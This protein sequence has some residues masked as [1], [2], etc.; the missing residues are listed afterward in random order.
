MS[1]EATDEISTFGWRSF[2]SQHAREANSDL[3]VCEG[4]IEGFN[5]FYYKAAQHTSVSDE[6][7]IITQ[8]N[9]TNNLEI[10]SIK[11]LQHNIISP[12]RFTVVRSRLELP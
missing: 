12:L 2:K 1:R 8:C 5:A 10:I 4:K 7:K 9:S 6:D 3:Y 11:A